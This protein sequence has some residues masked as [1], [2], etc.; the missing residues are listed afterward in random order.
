MCLRIG[1]TAWLECGSGVEC[2]QR[3]RSRSRE[4]GFYSQCSGKQVSY[5]LQTS[6]PTFSVL[7]DLIS[8]SLLII[9]LYQCARL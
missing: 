6:S 7:L 2:W 3:M 5:P 4:F 1:R 8:F 9:V